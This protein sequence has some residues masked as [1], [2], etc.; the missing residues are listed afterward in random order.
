MNSRPICAKCYRFQPQRNKTITGAPGNMAERQSSKRPPAWLL[1]LTRLMSR[2]GRGPMTGIDRVEAA[3]L[4]QLLRENTPLFGLVR[5]SLGFV[6]LDRAGMQAVQARLAGNTKW[7]KPDLL[8]RFFLKA[9][10]AR[11]AAESDLRRLCIKRASPAGLPRLLAQTLPAGVVWLNVGHTNLDAATFDAVHSIVGARAHV[12]VHDMIP[13]IYP[14]YQRPGTVSTFEQRMKTISAKADMVLY[15]SGQSQRDATQYFE[16]WGRIPTGLVAHLGVEMPTPEPAPLPQGV[17]KSAPYFVTIGTIEP[18]KNHALLLDIW[19]KWAQDMA[20]DNAP[21]PPLVIIGSRGWNNAA[22]F[23]RLDAKP[24]GI[25]ELNG[26]SDAQMAALVKNARA[27][28]FPSL[29]EGFGLPVCEAA[30]LGCEIVANDLPVTREILG[31]IP[32]YANAQDMYSWRDIIR[33]LNVKPKAEQSKQQRAKT[34][35]SLPT[36][37][38]HFNTVLNMSW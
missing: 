36:W 25:V 6:V 19:E 30:L 16:S 10:P 37:Q 12:L 21:L 2:V 23:R 33:E 35:S 5:S 29:A 26:L 18:R 14:Q 8:S 38:N 24:T 34:V 32:I 13:L 11:R 22:V 15:N 1:D 9:T 20:P 31:N 27:A 4:A 3:Y 28:L 17:D 7:G